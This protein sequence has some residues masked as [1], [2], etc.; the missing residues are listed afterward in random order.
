M[1]MATHDLFRMLEGPYSARLH[2]T[3]D[4]LL[5]PDMRASLGR[6]YRR[7]DA[8][9]DSATIGFRDELSKQNLP[10]SR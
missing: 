4:H 9:T 2:E 8:E 10:F 7:S 6:W 1:N 3:I 5:S